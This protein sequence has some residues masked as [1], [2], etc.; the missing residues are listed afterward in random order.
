M[1]RGGSKGATGPEKAAI[2][3]LSFGEEL[4]S[5]VIEKLSDGEMTT[6]GNYMAMLGSVETAKMDEVCEE[7][8]QHMRTG[9]GGIVVGGSD[10]VKRMLENVYQDKD[11]VQ[12]F[13]QRLG[14]PDEESG[15]YG[16]GL[17]TIRM[18]E[19]NT[20][21]SYRRFSVL[22]YSNA[23]MERITTG[24]TECREKQTRIRSES[25]EARA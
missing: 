20:I 4:A 19:P 9:E 8:I 25:A 18:L 10:Y 5:S 11:K 16:G 2:L 14:S 22:R 24:G 1:A 13:M 3:L 23:F 7:F 21:A 12:L 15:E 17:D 6:I